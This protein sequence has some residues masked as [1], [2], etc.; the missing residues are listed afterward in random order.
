[1]PVPRPAATLGATSAEI[2]QARQRFSKLFTAPGSLS[3]LHFIAVATVQRWALQ[4]ACTARQGTSSGT[5]I[6][7]SSRTM[8]PPPL[9]RN[10]CTDNTRFGEFTKVCVRP[11]ADTV[12]SAQR[13]S[14]V[15]APVVN[16]P[17]TM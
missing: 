1:V 14:K 16:P 8:L 7:T 3:R 15:P 11:N 5:A 13:V 17:S 2:E 10:V 12:R 9:V 6:D 4:Q